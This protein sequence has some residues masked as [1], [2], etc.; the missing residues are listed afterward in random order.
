MSRTA[1]LKTIG[2]RIAPLA[3][4][5][6]SAGAQSATNDTTALEEIVVTARKREE[7]IQTTPVSITA[8]TEATLSREQIETSRISAITS[9]ISPK[10]AVRGAGPRRYR[11]PSGASGNRTSI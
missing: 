3:L 7:P 1:A 2:G 4:L 10:S 9:R 11:C 6:Y 5:A 8:L